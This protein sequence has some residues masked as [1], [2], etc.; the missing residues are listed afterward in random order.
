MRIIAVV[1]IRVDVK[2]N[3]RSY[4]FQSTTIVPTTTKTTSTDVDA[5]EELETKVIS[6]RFVVGLVGFS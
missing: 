1:L 5:R 6:F 2:L 3:P 4:S